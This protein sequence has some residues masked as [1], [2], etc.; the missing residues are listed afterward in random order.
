MALVT[1]VNIE[2]ITG[3]SCKARSPKS[4]S[5][6]IKR[7]YYNKEKI[8]FYKNCRNRY[9]NKFSEKIFFKKISELL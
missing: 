7:I 2:K 8:H 9:K 4:L 6:I 3:Y 1:R 5:K